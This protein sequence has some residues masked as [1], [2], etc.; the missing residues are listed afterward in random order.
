MGRYVKGRVSYIYSFRGDAYPPDMSYLLRVSLLDRDFPPR[1]QG[2]V[3]C[4]GGGSYIEG[5]II[6]SG[7]HCQSIG[8]NFIGN[9]AIGGDPIGADDNAVDLRL[10]HKI[11]SHGIGDQGN[12]DTLLL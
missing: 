12:R 4:A 1:R 7:K 11:A 9:I 10:I 2:E 6:F 5:N 8:A 3:Y